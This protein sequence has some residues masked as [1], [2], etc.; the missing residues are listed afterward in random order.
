M[1]SESLLQ[2]RA[3]SVMRGI[4]ILDTALWDLNA[5]AAKLP[6]HLFLGANVTD[7]VPAYA[8]GGYY[9]A[10]KTPKM[11]GQE[12]ASLREGRLQGSQD[13]GRPPLAEGRGSAHPRRARGDRPGRPPDAR[14]QQRLERRAD[15]APLHE[16]LRA[17][18]PVLDRGA[19]RAGRDR[20]AR[21]PRGADTG[22]RRHRRD[23]LR[24]LVSQG[25]ARQ[26][27]RRDHPDRRL[28]VRR[29]HR[30]E[31]HRGAGGGLR[32]HRLPALVPRRARPARRRDAQR[33]LRRVL[34]RRPGAQL[35]PP[36]RQAA[37]VQERR[38]ACC[39]RRRAWDSGSTRA[40]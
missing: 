25:A 6:L 28:R 34:H 15:R 30:M 31:A 17:L 2:G 14:R 22:R 38:P 36:H 16:A 23:R 40:Q 37:G 18:R 29:H 27:R 5:R 21:A 3:G 39:T 9:L 24:P 33:A 20:H 32:R 12:M 7:K 26:A 19:V 1:Y 13:E 4:S 35:P 8:S 11:L 10:G